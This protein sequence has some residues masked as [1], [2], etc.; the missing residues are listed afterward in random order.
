[1]G[2]IRM[3]D[4]TTKY[5]V[6]PTDPSAR[7]LPVEIAWDSSRAAPDAAL[8]CEPEPALVWASRRTELIRVVVFGC[9]RRQ[10]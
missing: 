4:K 7:H 8:S 10:T 5:C 3:D 6:M 2:G 9:P 1:M